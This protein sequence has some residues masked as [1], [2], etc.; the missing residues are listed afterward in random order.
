[1]PFRIGAG[2]WYISFTPAI[3]YTSF[4]ISIA[5]YVAWHL[6]KPR[7]TRNAIPS[8]QTSSRLPYIGQLLEYGADP[9][10][11][12]LKQKNVVGEVF[13]LDLVF[14]NITF[15]IGAKRAAKMIR[16]GVNHHGRLENITQASAQTSLDIYEEWAQRN[17][18]PLFAAAFTLLV[19][20]NLITYF[21]H[22]FVDTHT[23]EL[24]T[25]A[26]SCMQ[27]LLSP[28]ARLLPLWA[29]QS[30]RK[31][32]AAQARLTELIR[33]EIPERLKHIDVC[34]ESDDYLSFLLTQDYDKGVEPCDSEYTLYFSMPF[35]EACLRET[36][37][38]Y[39]NLL[40]ARYVTREMCG[41]DG[42]IIPRGWTV[43][44]PMAVHR[45]PALY[46]KP[47]KWD[48]ARFLPAAD[49]TPSDYSTK[50]RNV[51]FHQF[52]VGNHACPGER[53]SRS[54]LQGSLWPSLLD[55]YQLELV[56]DIV[57]GEGVDG[58]GV[59]PDYG[60]NLS[61]PYAGEHEV[62]IKVTKRTVR[63]SDAPHSATMCA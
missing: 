44:S 43:A 4:C 28:W 42:I 17:R 26:D 60:K 63:P 1:M 40:T 39:T 59:K 54:L 33:V 51:E 6:R 14:M 18:V 10:R 8:A 62:F 25:M 24:F 15:L 19:R 50:L 27:A 55:N 57:D 38:L 46:D 16:L 13:R 53:L 3:S 9:L 5:A 47:D 37:R 12:I 32:N 49:G 11:F 30:G 41:P 45:D 31:L 2:H 34:R 23:T 29:I 56:G 20:S 52:G 36:G 21:G 58:V 48:P 35:A 7:C 61:T 22:Q